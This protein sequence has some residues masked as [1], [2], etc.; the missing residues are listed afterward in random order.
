MVTI[1][2][3][4]VA[5]ARRA[6]DALRAIEEQGPH[7]RPTGTDRFAWT[8]DV[9]DELARVAGVLGRAVDHASGDE[10]PTVRREAA[11]LTDAIIA[12]RNTMLVPSPHGA[13][14]AEAARHDRSR[15]AAGPSPRPDD[16]H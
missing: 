15:D 3:T 1:E 4:A 8:A 6:H 2:N 5:L 14:Y 16:Q 12:H 7:V 10:C 13:K 11:E 9:L